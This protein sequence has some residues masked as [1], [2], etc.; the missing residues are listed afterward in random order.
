MKTINS[1]IAVAVLGL[2]TILFAGNAYAF[3]EVTP[4]NMMDKAV[5]KVVFPN[6]QNSFII[7]DSEGKIILRETIKK[8]SS[9]AKIYNFSNVDDGIYTL[10]STIE[11][12]IATTKIMVKNSSIEVI[13]NEVD[14]K[15]VF[16][17]KDNHLLVNYLNLEQEEIE[18]VI[19]NS[20]AE[21]YRSTEGNSQVYQ[22][23]FHFSH[24]ERGEY[25]ATITVGRK[26]Y[27]HSFY[28]DNYES[29]MIIAR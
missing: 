4:L 27:T 29:H 6:D 5:V 26:N 10:Y 3:L 8:G 7:A 9:T 28:I 19:Y 25:F 2:S 11:Y 21:L 17:I 24:H 1:L 15:P 14:Y 20:N 22:K 12:G 18:M 16:I 13:S 23:K